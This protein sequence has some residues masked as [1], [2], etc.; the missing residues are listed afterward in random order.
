[1]SNH[2]TSIHWQRKGQHFNYEIY[3]RTFTIKFSGD[4]NIQASNS[5]E[6]LGKPELPNSEEP[7]VSALSGCYMQTFLTMACKYGYN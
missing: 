4:E 6:Y 2:L 3:D 1:M 5:K 7:L